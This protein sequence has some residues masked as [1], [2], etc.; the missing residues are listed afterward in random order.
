M[1]LGQEDLHG[2]GGIGNGGGGGASAVIYSVNFVSCLTVFFW[3]LSCNCLQT[4]IVVFS[5]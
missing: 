3:K 2:R 4:H 1:H 5:A